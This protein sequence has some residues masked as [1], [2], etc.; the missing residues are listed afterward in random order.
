MIAFPLKLTTMVSL[1]TEIL[2][3]QMKWSVRTQTMG[4]QQN[5][6]IVHLNNSL[7]CS[8][9]LNMHFKKLENNTF[10]NKSYAE[11]AKSLITFNPNYSPF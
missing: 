1:Q 11:D 5:P 9:K 3:Q 8:V 2:L 10:A 7:L 4:K 6:V